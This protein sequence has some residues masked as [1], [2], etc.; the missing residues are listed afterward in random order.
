MNPGKIFISIM[1]FRILSYWI[2]IT[3]ET[4]PAF[5]MSPVQILMYLCMDT[6]LITVIYYVKIYLNLFNNCA[7]RVKRLVARNEFFHHTTV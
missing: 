3:L 1:I 5:R 2:V 7:Q 6:K 4:L